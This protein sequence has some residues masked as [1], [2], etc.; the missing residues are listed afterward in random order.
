VFRIRIRSLRI[1]IQPKT[2]MRIRIQSANRMWIRIQAFLQRSFWDM[3][4]EYL[5][6]FPSFCNTRGECMPL[7]WNKTGKCINLC[8]N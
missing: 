2:S 4:Y 5:G 3:K 7:F 1:Q 8:D 6:S